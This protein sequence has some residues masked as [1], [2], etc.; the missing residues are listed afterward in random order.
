[1][2]N[3][4]TNQKQYLVQAEEE[5]ASITEF[6][7]NS[8]LNQSQGF[9]IETLISDIK[10][11]EK[12][13]SQYCEHFDIDNPERLVLSAI[14]V[15]PLFFTALVSFFNSRYYLFSGAF[16]GFIG[17]LGWFT[18]THGC[19]D[20]VDFLRKLKKGKKLIKRKEDSHQAFINVISNKDF[21][22]KILY[23]LHIL[24]KKRRDDSDIFSRDWLIEQYESLKKSFNNHDYETTQKTLELICQA[25]DFI[26]QDL[27]NT[28]NLTTYNREL[29]DF[30]N[31]KDHQEKNMPF[32]YH[33]QQL[34][35]MI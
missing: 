35:Y 9:H 24:A 13:Y 6:F 28:I 26:H 25:S 31:E 19:G 27:L 14:M 12:Q 16:I 29:D 7:N 22:F 4:M 3:K 34:K 10:K 21:Q 11:S 1:M 33:V 15:L 2:D 20:N 17:A 30:I 5:K 23:H 8:I 18:I 32:E